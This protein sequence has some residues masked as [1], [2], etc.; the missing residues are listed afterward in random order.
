MRKTLLATTVAVSALVVGNAVAA[1]AQG[2]VAVQGDSMVA[3]SQA[4]V[5]A[6]LAPA[7]ITSY[8]ARPARSAAAA[9]TQLAH[10]RLAGVVVFDAGTDIAES[11]AAYRHDLTRA[12]AAL[13]GDQR[14]VVVTIYSHGRPSADDAVIHQFAAAR[15]T[16]VV[17]ADWAHAIQSRHVRLRDGSHPATAAGW[18][19]FAGVIAWAVN[20]AQSLPAASPTATPGPASAPTPVATAPPA[21]TPTPP[22]WTIPGNAG[23]VTLP[24][25]ADPAPVPSVASI[26]WWNANGTA[27]TAGWHNGQC[28]ELAWEKR[29]DIVALIA[30]DDHDRWVSSGYALPTPDW[31]ATFWDDLA[32][33]A[34]IP[35]GTV[36]ERGAIMVFNSSD[37]PT[38]PGH[39][40]YVDSVNA[41]GS[42][43]IA[44]ENAPTPGVISIRTVEPSELT[45]ADADF[46]YAIP[47]TLAAV[48]GV[49]P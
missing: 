34:G 21:P 44:E 4:Y 49:G 19:A 40:A 6:Q 13:R 38:W 48:G 36:P 42:F 22:P 12:F 30:E 11:A 26:A 28:T 18:K 9:A 1:S 25:V 16:R 17:V 33:G 10:Q 24:T 43:V 35:V 3:S 5:R 8:S 7:A 32:A 23:P 29:P 27:W 15:R 31:D 41:D 39:L 37:Y 2:T 47:P 14:L 46:I 20:A 45:G